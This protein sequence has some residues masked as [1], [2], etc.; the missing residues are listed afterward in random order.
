LNINKL[1]YLYVFLGGE[2]L[3][4]FLDYVTIN[5]CISDGLIRAYE[6]ELR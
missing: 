6:V 5:P 1:R 3:S 2:L 4:I